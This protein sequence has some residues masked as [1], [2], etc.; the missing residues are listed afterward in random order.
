MNDLFGQLFN[1][2]TLKFAAILFIGVIVTFGAIIGI[3]AIMFE[4]EPEDILARKPAIYL[5]PE[6]TIQVKV[7]L[8]LKGEITVSEPLYGNGWDV[9]AYPNG[10][11]ESTEGKHDYLFYEAKLDKIDLPQKG[12]CID[13]D[14]IESWMTKTLDKLGLNEKESGE[15]KEY[16]LDT[17]PFMPFYEIRL[18]SQEYI[19]DYMGLEISPAPDTIIRVHLYFEG[20]SNYTSIENPIISKPVRNGFTVVEW[21]G[22]LV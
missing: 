15:F 10:A 7:D 6:T 1:T 3:E 19:D 20:I 2:K 11:I 14:S 9:I 18:L 4:P 5:Y 22:F 21:G 13:F 17:L 12:W 8:F 16:W